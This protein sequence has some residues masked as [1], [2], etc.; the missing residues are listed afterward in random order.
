MARG[1]MAYFGT[2]TPSAQ[3][4]GAARPMLGPGASILDVPTTGVGADMGANPRGYGTSLR[5]AENRGSIN[6]ATLGDG[7]GADPRVGVEGS[8]P[9]Y[10]PEAAPM[11]DTDIRTSEGAYKALTDF[12]SSKGIDPE[13]AG[14]MT[15]RDIQN[16][17]MDSGSGAPP[18]QDLINALGTTQADMGDVPLEDPSMGPGMTFNP[19]RPRY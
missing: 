18:D 3:R 4:G 11:Y 15:L 2:D 17:L 10:D 1:K 19:D 14:N 8:P 16:M 5:D 12:L 6:P 9:P 13:A 7:G